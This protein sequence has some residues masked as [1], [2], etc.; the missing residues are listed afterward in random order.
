MRDCST[1]GRTLRSA[2]LNWRNM[3]PFDLIL[4]NCCSHHIPDDVF[5]LELNSLKSLLT[6][7]GACL[8]VDILKIQEAGETALHRW[9]MKLEQGRHV[10]TKEE[11]LK[12]MSKHFAVHRI[13][14]WRSH[15][16]S[17]PCPLESP[18]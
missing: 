2:T 11:Y 17:F 16:F 13:T 6:P 7:K 8:L 5:E 14:R 15:L 12:L 18:L 10:R 3:R 9:F 4:I 1:R